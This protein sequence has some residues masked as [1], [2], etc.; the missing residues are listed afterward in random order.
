MLRQYAGVSLVK[1]RAAT[2]AQSIQWRLWPQD[3]P[4]DGWSAAAP[5]LLLGAAR[6]RGLRDCAFRDAIGSSVSNT[7][8]A[9]QVFLCRACDSVLSQVSQS[10][11]WPRHTAHRAMALRPG[12]SSETLSGRRRNGGPSGLLGPRS[13][14]DIYPDVAVHPSPRRVSNGE[15]AGPAECQ[16]GMMCTQS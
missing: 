9:D 14:G 15:G 8:S 11:V 10:R 12:K 13:F 2:Q 3:R 5:P 7:S 6:R 16:C 1:A 4:T